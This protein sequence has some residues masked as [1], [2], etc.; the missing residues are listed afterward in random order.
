MLSLFVMQRL[1]VTRHAHNVLILRDDSVNLSVITT[2][3]YWFSK[4]L[5]LLRNILQLQK[6]LYGCKGLL[7]VN[8][9]FYFVSR[10]KLTKKIQEQ[11]NLGKVI[12]NVI[13]LLL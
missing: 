5:H 12:N 3:L 6:L 2:Y 4:A 11:E 9:L 10:E 8:V 13:S 7:F 1:P